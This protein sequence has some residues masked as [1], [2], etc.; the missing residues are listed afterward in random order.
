M[1]EWHERGPAGLPR[2]CEECQHGARLG[3]P[4]EVRPL[5]IEARQSYRCPYVPLAPESLAWSI[6]VPVPPAYSGSE[7]SVCP[8]YTTS[9][10]E[11]IEGA[12]AWRHWEKADVRAFTGGSW[13]TEA[14]TR[15]IE[16]FDAAVNA[17]QRWC[18]DNPRKD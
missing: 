7:L 13:P 15:A 12:R 5:P 9:L 10:P 16:T 2:S 14:L 1:Q 18:A 3:Q 4:D 8:V 17:N 11:T 6:R